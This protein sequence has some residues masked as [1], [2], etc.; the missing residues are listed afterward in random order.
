VTFW[1]K[2]EHALLLLELLECGEIRHRSTQQRAWSS[3]LELGWARRSRRHDVLEI[4]PAFRENLET[5]LDGAWPGWR[6]TARRLADAGQPPTPQ[7]MLELERQMRI[8]RAGDI[9]LP[10]RIN[11]RTAAAVVARHSKAKLG[12]FERIALDETELTDDGLVRMRPS[13]GLTVVRGFEEH[14]ASA[15]AEL[16]GDLVL[17][18]R[19]LR[20]GTQLAGQRPRAVLTVENLGAFQDAVVANDI[21]VVHVP[22]WNTGTTRDL[23][24][25]LQDVPVLHFGDLDPNGIAI[26]K[27]LRRWRPDV[28]WLVPEYWVEIVDERGLEGEWPEIEMPTDAPPWV[29]ELPDRRLWLEQ[30]AVV[31][32]K[33]FRS[34]VDS[35]LADG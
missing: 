1:G 12:P 8:D 15:L 26:L 9:D 30:E 11:R 35:S 23:L 19:A 6:D 13:A 2:R 16:L 5:T 32:D 27:H 21:L 18:D 25:G 22:G 14:S 17:T 29:R 34:S 24:A 33:R 4:D 3:V 20:D 31:V 10:S 7:G 28:R